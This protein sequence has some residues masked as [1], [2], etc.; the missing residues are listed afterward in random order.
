MGAA[1]IQRV[2]KD[3]DN[4]PAAVMVAPW[5]SHSNLKDGITKLF[6]LD[7]IGLILSV[8]TCNPTF[9]IRSPKRAKAMF[10]TENSI[11][12]QDMLFKNLNS[13]SGFVMYGHNPPFWHPSN[14]VK[15]P[16]LWMAGK[17]DAV[18]GENGVM[19]SAEFYGVDYIAMENTGHNI[20]VE[21]NYKES[22]QLIHNW[23]IK[24][25]IT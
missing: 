5:S 15:T 24:Q 11:C 20:M 14:D 13:D 10:L 25:N 19:E 1:L 17:L 22:A 18:L 21:N 6:R 2:L 4:F 23:L 3:M 16:M 7:P 8:L 9:F 12:S